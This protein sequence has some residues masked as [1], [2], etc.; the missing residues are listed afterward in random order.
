MKKIFFIIAIAI[1]SYS[2]AQTSD[3][4]KIWTKGGQIGIN[5]SQVGFY[6]WSK[7][8]DNNM[9]GTSFLNLF[10]NRNVDGW[11]WENK[12]DLEFGLK[13]EN[14]EIWKKTDDRIEINTKLGKQTQNKNWF[15]T[16]YLNFKTQ[17]TQGYDYDESESISISDFMAPAYLTLGPSMDYKPNE[18]FSAMISPAAYKAVFVLNQRLADQGEFGVKEAE[19][20]ATGLLIKNG[21]TIRHEFGANLVLSFKKDIFKNVTLDTKLDLFSNY[22]E[23][24]ENV[25]VDW[26]ATLTMKVNDYLNVVFKTHLI[27]D[28]NTN[29]EWEDEDG[30]MHKS[31]ITQFKE[32]LAV[33]LMYKF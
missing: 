13:R 17:F 10:A 22:L 4:T 24:P 31:P 2:F 23:N 1:G 9:A 11:S 15:Y 28:D 12:L 33:G 32:S 25:D 20:D 18:Y 7:G 26:Q 5:A 6:N 29:V 19:Y 8:G 21:E 16:G 14:A 3:T 30:V 27:Y